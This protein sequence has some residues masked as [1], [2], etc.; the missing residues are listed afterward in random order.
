VVK[1]DYTVTVSLKSPHA[2]FLYNLARQGSVIYPRE[3]VD[4]LK[5]A[6]V[7]TGPFTLAE[8]LRG[9]RIVLAWPATPTI[10]SRDCRVSIA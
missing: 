1:D 8:W 10:T 5:R 2:A 3:A 4:T 6:P 9:D 7:G